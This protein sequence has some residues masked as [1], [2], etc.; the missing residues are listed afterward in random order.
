MEK[1]QSGN[2]FISKDEISCALQQRVTITNS[3]KSDTT[4][5]FKEESL[6]SL[7]Q[8]APALYGEIFGLTKSGLL[9]VADKF[10]CGGV[11]LFAKAILADDQLFESIMHQLIEKQ[12]VRQVCCPNGESVYFPTELYLLRCGL[13]DPFLD[14]SP[15]RIAKNQSNSRIEP[16]NYSHL[17][18][19]MPIII[20]DLKDL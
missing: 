5:E 17:M 2:L 10:D 13:I 9:A 6:A 20:L 12:L 19:N 1:I 8:I 3:I 18:Q 7:L 14:D 11:S 15:P 4:G 16:Q